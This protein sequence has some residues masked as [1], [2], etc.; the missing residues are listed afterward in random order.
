M[1]GFTETLSGATAV[2]LRAH[3]WCPESCMKT[4]VS[5]LSAMMIWLQS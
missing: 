5:A 4:Q 1:F 2:R 3:H